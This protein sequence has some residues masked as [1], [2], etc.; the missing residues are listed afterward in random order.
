MIYIQFKYITLNKIYMFFKQKL[1][2]HVLSKNGTTIILTE[3][4]A[5]NS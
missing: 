1:S 5:A 4:I 3:N 2:K